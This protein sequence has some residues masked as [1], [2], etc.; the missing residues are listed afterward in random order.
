MSAAERRGS[1]RMLRLVIGPGH[2]R[3]LCRA[4]PRGRRRNPGQLRPCS[5]WRRDRPQTNIRIVQRGRVEVLFALACRRR[6][7][8]MNHCLY[9]ALDQPS[10]YALVQRILAPGSE[11]LISQRIREML[12]G[13]P[14]GEPLLDL[15]CGPKSWLTGAGLKPFG[16]DINP[17][18]VSA[19][20]SL[21]GVG[22]V[23]S[24]AQ[25]PF[26]SNSF[27]GV[28][29]VGLLHHLPDEAAKCTLREGIRVCRPGGYVAILDAVT[30]TVT[31]HR[32]LATM[33]RKLD[34]GKFM[35]SEETL[36]A[37]L[38]DR[39]KWTY[40]RFTFAMTGLEMLACVVKVR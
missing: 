36:Q 3:Y 33:I 39:E 19:Y 5:R 13:L 6:N 17:A 27:G 34:R 11:K 9:R 35:R 8:R 26:Q 2:R 10:V 24:A 31:W 23:A 30:P 14:A 18:Y 12:S 40:T 21:G 25:I 16:L 15:G 1:P 4:S 28:W 29:S 37:L 7:T 20:S 38:P 32:P 22:I